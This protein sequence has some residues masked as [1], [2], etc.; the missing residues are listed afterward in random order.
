MKYLVTYEHRHGTDQTLCRT[1]NAAYICAMD[2]ILTW[3]EELDESDQKVIR[4]LIQAKDYEKALEQWEEIQGE[5]LNGETIGIQEIG[6]F[7]ARKGAKRIKELL[8]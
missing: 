1:A 4:E 7:D 8:A 6:F 5:R 2:I 3:I